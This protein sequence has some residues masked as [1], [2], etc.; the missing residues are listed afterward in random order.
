MKP[1]I[2]AQSY[3][4]RYEL[5]EDRVLLSVDLSPEHELAMALTRRLTRNFVAALA[6]FI[7][8]RGQ[9]P[10]VNPGLRDTILDFQHSQ[11]VATAIAQGNM[12][13]ENR[14]KPPAM[15]PRL[16]REVKIVPKPD[17]G[18]ALVFDNSE[19]LLVVEVAPERI[20]MVIAT[21]VQI[22]ERAGW[23]FPPIASW[24]DASK[25]VEAPAG[26]VVN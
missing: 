25:S 19:Q 26:R 21:F 7:A 11:S 13:D 18:L 1:Q 5:E 17:A 15:P 14:Q 24:L 12:R 6:K 10:D 9:V 4:L 16:V 22:S 8:D 20:H 23:D 2:N 3:H